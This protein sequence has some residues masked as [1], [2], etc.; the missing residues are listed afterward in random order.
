MIAFM[1]HETLLALGKMT[2]HTCDGTN[3]VQIDSFLVCTACGT[4]KKIQCMSPD[5]L[6]QCSINDF[7]ITVESNASKKQSKKCGAAS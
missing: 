4:E 3:L 2:C 7:S 6:I 5:M 1:D